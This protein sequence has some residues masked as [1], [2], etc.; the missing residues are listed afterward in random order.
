M[1]RE[2]IEQRAGQP[3]RT[4]DRGPLIE[5]Q[6]AGDQRGATFVALTEHLEE[7]FGTN[8]GERHVAQFIDDQQFDRVEV[9]LQCPQPAFVAR[10]HEFMHESGG[11]GECNALV[12]L[13][14]GQPQCQADVGFA[15]AG[16]TRGILPNITTPMGGSFIGITLATVRSWKF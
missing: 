9:F 5:W 11:R 13:A 1:M 4:E 10:F 16:R 7:Q 6:I 3:F 2:P 8:G 15:G 12:F 14:R